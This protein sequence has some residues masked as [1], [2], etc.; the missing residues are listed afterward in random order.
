VKKLWLILALFVPVALQAQ[1][2]PGG[3]RREML[4][5]EV[6]RRFM[7]HVSNQLQLDA[8][9]RGKLEQHLRQSGEQRR[10]LAQRSV[11]LRREA[12]DAVRDSTTPDAEYRR[13]LAEMT[14]LRLREENLWKDD[15]TA[16]GRILTPRQQLQFVFM[17]LRFNE[18][19]R[20]LARPPRGRQWE[21]GPPR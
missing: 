17:W 6:V 20:D 12:M 1:N 14:D 15:Q 5:G 8:T 19:I 16:L 13:L 18:Q 10:A 21:G 7:N 4:Q 9:T 3:P 2:P 11:Q